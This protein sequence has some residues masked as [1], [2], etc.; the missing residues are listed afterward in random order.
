MSANLR[1]FYQCRSTLYWYY[2]VLLP[3]AVS[4]LIAPF[5]TVPRIGAGRFAFYLLPMFLAGF[6]AATLQREALHKPFTF[7]LPGHHEIPRRL[8]FRVGWCLSVLYA[9]A[10]MI[11]PAQSVAEGL[12]FVGSGVAMGMTVYLLGVWVVLRTRFAT[13]MIGL[14]YFIMATL[15]FFGIH[16]L[17]EGL[18]INHP[19]ISILISGTATLLTWRKM[20]GKDLA[21][22]Y[23]GRAYL[24]G[25]SYDPENVRDSF[26]MKNRRKQK[27]PASA[28]VA[29]VDSF[30]L[31]RMKAR[32][33]LGRGRHMWGIVYEGLANFVSAEMRWWLVAAVLF[34]FLW[35][36]YANAVGDISHVMVF[37]IPCIIGAWMW[38][39]LPFLSPVLLP[40]GRSER[41]WGGIAALSASVIFAM[42]AVILIVVV[43]QVSEYFLPPISLKE[44]VFTYSGLGIRNVFLPLL[45]VPVFLVP[46]LLF[47]R[48]MMLAQMIPYMPIVMTVSIWLPFLHEMGSIFAGLL[49]AMV[50]LLTVAI[51]AYIC[52]RKDLVVQ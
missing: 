13:V 17:L 37:M 7:S 49:I 47:P 45:M 22:G 48:S 44:T 51:L 2:L 24:G 9:S 1:L 52:A 33:P 30:C 14:L 50:W 12:L 10:Y 29:A 19:I 46:R 20:E 39:P 40:A 18:I 27:E 3:I 21:R 16:I 11:H 26:K 5:L 38:A 36:Y 4:F 42:S 25:N 34:V 41:F 6:H 28:L 43:T 15:T 23:C 8:L 35:G 31:S 32:M